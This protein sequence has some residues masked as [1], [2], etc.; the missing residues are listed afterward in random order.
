MFKSNDQRDSA[1][2]KFYISG[3][4]TLKKKHVMM[5]SNVVRKKESAILFKYQGFFA[6]FCCNTDF[7]K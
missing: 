6:L 5:M 4:E 2:S 3:T 1:S 7:I